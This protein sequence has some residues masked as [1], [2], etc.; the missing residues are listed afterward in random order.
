MHPYY[1]FKCKEDNKLHATLKVSRKEV[2]SLRATVEMKVKGLV[3]YRYI[4]ARSR[5]YTWHVSLMILP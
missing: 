5:V 4:A 2:V 1:T 3:S